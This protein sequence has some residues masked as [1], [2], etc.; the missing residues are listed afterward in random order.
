MYY[1]KAEKCTDYTSDVILSVISFLQSIARSHPEKVQINF[2]LA[3][4]NDRFFDPTKAIED[5]ESFL[6]ATNDVN[7]YKHLRDHAMKRLESLKQLKSSL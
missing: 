3:F 1:L 5:Y 2:G 6:E 7:K 4:I